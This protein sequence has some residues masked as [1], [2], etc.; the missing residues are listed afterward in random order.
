MKV[1]V[2]GAIIPL[3][4]A[5]ISIIMDGTTGAGEDTMATD[6]A[7]VTHGYGATGV[8]DTMP[9]IDGVGTTTHGHGTT[10]AGEDITVTDGVAGI[11]LTDI[12]VITVT[13][14]ADITTDLIPDIGTL[15]ITP[16]T[17]VGEDTT[18]PTA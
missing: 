3:M 5:S 18:I 16:L 4:S 7:G 8:M 15:E 13:M 10:G 6:G 1:M 14:A 2:L 12:T 17:E 11:P 9:L